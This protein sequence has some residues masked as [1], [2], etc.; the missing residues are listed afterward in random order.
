MNGELKANLRSTSNVQIALFINR[1]NIARLEPTIF[2]YS[3]RRLLRLVAIAFHNSRIRIP[4][5][6]LLTTFEELTFSID[7]LYLY[8]R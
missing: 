1:A 2:R 8:V 6:S 3:E 7:N 4:Q 5:L